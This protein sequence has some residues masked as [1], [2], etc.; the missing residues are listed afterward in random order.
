MSLAISHL[1]QSTANL[2]ARHGMAGLDLWENHLFARHTAGQSIGSIPPVVQVI[3]RNR[4]PGQL[5]SRQ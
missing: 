4:R 3:N 1:Y 5:W 2:H